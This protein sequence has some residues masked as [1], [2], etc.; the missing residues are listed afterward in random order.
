MSYK[1]YINGFA[2]TMHATGIFRRAIEIYVLQEH[3][4]EEY[5]ITLTEQDGQQLLHQRKL[6]PLEYTECKPFLVLGN[7]LLP[8]IRTALNEFC[9]ASGV[10]DKAKDFT[11][12]KLTAT[13]KHLEDMRKLLKLK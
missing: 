1:V 13:E 12:G 8:H 6:N 3:N 10:P 7:D 4:G 5:E 11:E 2:P 9:E